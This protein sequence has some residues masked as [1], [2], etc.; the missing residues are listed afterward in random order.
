[1]EQLVDEVQL[2]PSAPKAMTMNDRIKEYVRTMHIPPITNWRELSDSEEEEDEGVGEGTQEQ[3]KFTSEID[4][5][6]SESNSGSF[7]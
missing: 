5:P 4:F 7:R 6:Q 1:M 3:A 2:E